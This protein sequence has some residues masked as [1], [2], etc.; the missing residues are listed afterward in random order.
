VSATLAT[1]LSRIIML[2]FLTCTNQ[3]IVPF[4][5]LV[6]DGLAEEPDNVSHL[7]LPSIIF[8]NRNRSILVE[9]VLAVLY[10]CSSELLHVVPVSS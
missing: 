5:F 2:D 7:M 10:L 9:T 6:G 1:E 3:A 8:G 4:V